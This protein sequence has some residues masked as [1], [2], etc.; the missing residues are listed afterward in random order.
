MVLMSTD[1]AAKGYHHA[2]KSI[3]PKLTADHIFV[4]ISVAVERGANFFTRRLVV[5]DDV[6]R[7]GP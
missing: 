1:G 3:T 6:F 5:L 7:E 4:R 2:R